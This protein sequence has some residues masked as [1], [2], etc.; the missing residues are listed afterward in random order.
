MASEIAI[1]PHGDGT[2]TAPE[3][4]RDEGLDVEEKDK[5]RFSFARAITSLFDAREEAGFEMEIINAERERRRDAGMDVRGLTIPQSLLGNFGP[6][7]QRMARFGMPVE[8]VMHQRSTLVA[9]TNNVGGDLVAEE[10][11]AEDFIDFLYAESAILPYTTMLENLQ[12]NIAIPKQTARITAGWVDETGTAPESNPTFSLV[13][14]QPT[15]MRVKVPYSRQLN[16]Q[17]S[18]GIENLLRQAIARSF[19]QFLDEQLVYGS[20]TAPAI[21]GIT[22]ITALGDS[23]KQLVQYPAAGLDYDSCLKAVSI[24]GKANALAGRDE[25]GRSVGSSGSRR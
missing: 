17:S 16:L 12:G 25:L 5:Q 2:A 9:G 19:A 1:V 15:D 23:T 21:K 4:N 14:L 6:I 20:G 13:Q 24:V 10:L 22:G 3:Q 11:R 8:E 18:I 7:K